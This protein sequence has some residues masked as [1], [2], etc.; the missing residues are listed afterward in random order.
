LS[1]QFGIL[2]FHLGE[3]FGF[4]DL[5]EDIVLL[6]QV[7]VLYAGSVALDSRAPVEMWNENSTIRE[8]SSF[9]KLLGVKHPAF[10][11]SSCAKYSDTKEAEAQD[12]LSLVVT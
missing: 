3:V 9:C 6:L 8:N 2:L 1:C 5:K 4:C 10:A 11:H 7:R 12:L